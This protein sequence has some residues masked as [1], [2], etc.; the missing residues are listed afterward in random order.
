[1]DDDGT[2]PHDFS[3]TVHIGQDVIRDGGPADQDPETNRIVLRDYRPDGF[4]GALLLDDVL[5]EVTADGRRI[6]DA[7]STSTPDL[8]EASP[9]YSVP[10]NGDGS[11][12]SVDVQVT[13]TADLRGF[14]ESGPG[15]YESV[16]H[17]QGEYMA[18]DDA[19]DPVEGGIISHARNGFRGMVETEAEGSA[20][21]E[22][23]GSVSA[24]LVEDRE[25]PVS[26]SP[27]DVTREMTGVSPTTLTG[28]LTLELGPGSA[29]RHPVSARLTLRRLED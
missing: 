11:A 14:F 27:S 15:D 2:S 21:G 5:F 20:R 7:G 10:G 1:V 28:T 24:E 12:Q 25:G 26:F 9:Q 18:V 8:T 29:V 23:L 4:G 17:L 6:V 13:L 22:D 16:V 19:G 3:L